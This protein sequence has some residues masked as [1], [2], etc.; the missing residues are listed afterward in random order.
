LQEK[1]DPCFQSEEKQVRLELQKLIDSEELWWRQPAKADWLKSGDRN[2]RFFHACANERKRRNTVGSITDENGTVWDTFR[3][4]EDAFTN[5]FTSLFTQG[6][7]GDFSSCLQPIS[8]RVTEDMNRELGK[9]FTA[10]EIEVALFQMEPLKAPGPDGLNANFFQQNWSTMRLEVCYTLL[11]VLNSGF[12]PAELNLTHVALILKKKNPICVTD[13]RPI[14]LC[15]VLYKLISKVLANRLK[16]ILPH[17][18][19]PTQSAFIPGRLI[20][21][22]VLAAYET[23]HTMHAGMKGKKGFMAVKLDMSK[24][25]DKVEWGFL[26]AVMKHMGFCERWISLILMCIQTVTYSIVVNGNP[27]GLITPSRGIRQGDPISPYLFLLCAKALSSMIQKASDDGLSTGVPT[28][29]RGPRISHLFFADDSLLFCR[30]NLMQWNQLS[31]ILHEYEMAS[32]QKMNANKTAIFFSKNTPMFEKEQI[33]A[34]AGIPTDQRYDTYL[35]LPTL[36]GKSRMS[37][38]RSIKEKVWKRL[39]DWK[40]N[41]LSQAGK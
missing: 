24:A 36:V 38:F 7:G 10:E 12:L 25:Y 40:I 14:S 9:N 39:Q 41:F 1:E 37:A 8:C 29:R 20:T 33:Q 21:D 34:V 3:G 23:L 35:G 13:F 2:T 31:N 18:I 4:V 28:S 17:L 16:N 11:E 32:R 26:E 15:N 30:A 6:P 27:C 19:A 22:N 5:Y